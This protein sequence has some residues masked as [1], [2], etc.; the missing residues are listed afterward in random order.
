MNIPGKEVD[1][2]RVVESSNRPLT[3]K[4]M[5]G[6]FLM[7]D[8]LM[9]RLFLMLATLAILAPAVLPAM[10]DEPTAPGGGAPPAA[11]SSGSTAPAKKLHGLRKRRAARRAARKAAKQGQQ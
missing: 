4:F 7:E 2:T 8:R 3:V 1:A 10:A 11:G 6:S 5:A 9:K